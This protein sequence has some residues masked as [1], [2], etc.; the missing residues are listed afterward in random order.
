M[1]KSIQSILFGLSGLALLGILELSSHAD[2]PTAV[3]IAVSGAIEG[4]GTDATTMAITF[5][6]L[7][8]QVNGAYVANPDG[9]LSAYGAGRTG[10]TLSYYFCNNPAHKGSIAPCSDPAHDPWNYMRLIIKDGALVGKGQSAHVIFPAGSSWEIWRK[11]R[12]GD[13]PGGALEGSG[14]LMQPV[15]YQETVLR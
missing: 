13:P 14:Q 2:K 5:S 6:G 10:Q 11:A 3:L 8:R 12:P 15:T 7:D 9:S 4:S 1:R